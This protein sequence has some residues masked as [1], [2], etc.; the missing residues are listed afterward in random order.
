MTKLQHLLHTFCKPQTV[1]TSI[2][3][4]LFVAVCTPL[5]AQTVNTIGT[6]VFYTNGYQAEDDNATVAQDKA[7]YCNGWMNGGKLTAWPSGTATDDR[8]FVV[9]AITNPSSNATQHDPWVSSALIEYDQPYPAPTE[10]NSYPNHCLGLCASFSCSNLPVGQTTYSVSF[11]LQRITFDI[12][13]YYNG[14]NP[15]NP[16]EVPS[17]RSIDVFPAQDISDPSKYTCGSYRCSNAG[18]D[19]TKNSRISECLGAHWICNGTSSGLS[20]S[21]TVTCAIVNASGSLG[22]V[23]VRGSNDYSNYVN[24]YLEG[25]NTVVCSPSGSSTTQSCT[26][27]DNACVIDNFVIPANTNSSYCWPSTS[28]FKTACNPDA[29]GVPQNTSW[30]TGTA[31]NDKHGCYYF[32]AL[33]SFSACEGAAT[34][35]TAYPGCCTGAGHSDCVVFD[36]NG[37]ETNAQLNFCTGWDGFYEMAGEF[38]KSN[39]Q[40][41]YRATAYTNVPSDGVIADRIEIQET[42][43]YPGHNGATQIPIQIDVTNVHTVRSTPSLVGT[44]TPV[45]AQPYTFTYRL[46]K[47]ADVRIA[48][49]DAST[50]DDAAYAASTTTG[51]KISSVNQA[52]CN[53]AGGTWDATTGKCNVSSITDETECVNNGYSYISGCVVASV[54]ASTCALAG[55]VWLGGECYTS[56]TNS[57]NQ[58]NFAAG[59]DYTAATNVIVRTLVDWQ[60]RTGEGMKGTDKDTQISDFD[61]WDGRHDEGFLLPAGNYIASIQAKSQDEWPGIDFSRAVTRQVSLDPLKLTDVQVTG[62]NKKSTAYATIS[63]VPTEPSTVYWEVYTPGTT[64]TGP[65]G[66]SEIL[67]D[68]SKPTGT[69][70]TISTNATDFTGSLVYRSVEQKSGRMNYTQRWDGTCQAKDASGNPTNCVR[71]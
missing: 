59:G 16:D 4:I 46:S 25:E 47:D 63:Y 19:D 55:D 12:F 28:T 44:I 15:K 62:L 67:T 51:T 10:E 70:P 60:P 61:S 52:F 21:Q 57:S 35:A 8:S 26:L 18:K 37:A 50:R 48:I 1:K 9:D 49:F 40:F 22:W 5:F 24:C 56:V 54:N 42:G 43:V 33:T 45:S 39:G 14:K 13:K 30:S 29:N 36:G 66:V 53:D 17:I 7:L 71:S 64:F 3:T 69:G 27:S 6:S 41:G 31:F 20:S 38:G 65:N 34:S 23:C 11:P 68:S 2:L 32:S 58:A